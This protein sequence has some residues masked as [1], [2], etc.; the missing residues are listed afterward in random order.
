M[1][2]LVIRNL[3][4]RRRLNRRNTPLVCESSRVEVCRLIEGN[5]LLRLIERLVA[6]IVLRTGLGNLE[7][8]EMLVLERLVLQI[9]G[10]ASNSRGGSFH[11][12]LVLGRVGQRLRLRLWLWLL[13]LC[14]MLLL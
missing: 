2:D 14:L 1:L 4:D 3:F 12:R 5:P 11:E 8:V 6:G 9:N 13:R 10:T 7:L